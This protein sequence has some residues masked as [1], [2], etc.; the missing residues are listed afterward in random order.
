[1]ISE[2]DLKSVENPGSKRSFAFADFSFDAER[3]TL[4]RG[5]EIVSLPP[6]TCELLGVL[7]ENAGEILLK[8]E[9]MVAVWKETFVEEANLSHH[10]TVLRKAL[11]ESRSGK[12]FIQTIPRK[13]YRFVAPVSPPPGALEITVSE[14]TT[15]ETFEEIEI[16]T[17]EFPAATSAPPIVPRNV[18]SRAANQTAKRAAIYFSIALL[19]LI[20]I[21]IFAWFKFTSI[22]NADQNRNPKAQSPNPMTVTRITNSGKVGASSISPDGKFIVYSQNHSD[23]VGTIYIRQT[24]TNIETRLATHERGEFGTKIFSPDSSFVFYIARDTANPAYTIYRVPVLGGPPVRLVENIAD[25]NFILSPDGSQAAILRYDNNNKQSSLVAARLDGSGM[26]QVLTTRPFQEMRLLSDGAWSPDGQKIVIPVKTIAATKNYS[27]ETV[28]VMM[29]DLTTGE[30]K[31]FTEET[32]SEIGMMRWMPDASGVVVVGKRPNVRNH[33]YF[34]SY[35]AGEVSRITTDAG[36]YGNYGLGITADGRTMVADVWEFDGRLWTMN[37][38]GEAK[39]AARLPGGNTNGSGGLTTMP[40]GR[41]IYG[42]RAASSFDL[43]T[44]SENEAEPKPLTSDAFFDGGAV[45]SPDGSFIVFASDRAGNGTSHLF[46]MNTDGSRIEQLTFDEGF[47]AMPDISPDGAFVVYHSNSYD[48]AK[49]EWINSIRKIPS[50]GGRPVQLIEQ[51]FAPSFS[52]DGQSFACIA[53]TDNYRGKIIVAGANAGQA[54]KTFDVNYYFHTFLPAR[55]TPDGT[56]IV[57][58]NT[59]NQIG[60]LWKQNLSGGAP[61]KLTDF[62]SE[63]IHDFIFTRDGKRL[64]LS[65]GS[66]TVNVVML[67]NFR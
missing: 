53:P 4:W 35:P 62:K 40:D 37:A 10:I 39:T 67:K 5:A 47:E 51:C 29:F 24:D 15:T 25:A 8:E 1:M 49:A 38:S 2:R 6:K 50:A 33:I 45:V 20:G 58:R 23:G 28:N 61:V 66:M 26:E 52:P 42:A 18:N 56:A 13:G 11:G 21:A 63:L 43:W 27:Q 3:K 17:G 30:L 34:I 19:P 31:N 46:R 36:S 32:W 65:R 57:F 64:L 12:K 59:E 55:W 41:I 60:N 16:E 7:V 22:P 54:L 14:R 48:A 9:L 44:L